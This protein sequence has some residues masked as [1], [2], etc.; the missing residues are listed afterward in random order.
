DL[1]TG[2]QTCALPIWI[3]EVLRPPGETDVT[4]PAA[5]Q[6]Q[7]SGSRLAFARWLAS[8]NNPLTARVFVNRVWMH[9]VGRG[10]VETP[11]NFG[12]M[13][14]APTHPELLD[15]LAVDFMRTAGAPSG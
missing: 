11:D 7:T 10:I 1:V 14:A 2:V 12:R 5:A 6:G 13:G 4:R 8:R 15:W 9:L 3:P